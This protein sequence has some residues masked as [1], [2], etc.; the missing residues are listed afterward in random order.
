MKNKYCSLLPYAIIAVFSA[1]LINNMF[2]GFSWTDEGLYLSNVQRYLSGDRFLIDDW[3]PTQFYEPLL[4]P[5]YAFFIKITGSTDGIFLFFRF[6]T[7]IF[8]SLASFF[9]YSLLSKR[10]RALSS[11]FASLIVLSFSRACL[12]GPSYYTIGFE[13]YLIALLCLYAFFSLSCSRAFLFVSGIFFASSIL[14]N[15]F[16][17]FPYIAVSIFTLILPLSRKHIKEIA[18]VWLGS[19]ASGIIYMIFVF[20]GN[21]LSDILSGLHYTY[22]DPSYKHTIILTIKRLYKMPRLLI[23]P[24][25]IT[26]LP[27]IAL[28]G[29]IKIK[30]IQLTVRKK[31][32]MHMLNLVLFFAN[33]FVRKD[34]GAAVMTF[35]HFTIFEVLLFSDLQLKDFLLEYKNELLYFVI[36]GL[37]LAIFFCFASDTGFGVCAVGMALAAVGEI[38]IVERCLKKTSFSGNTVPRRILTFAPFFILVAFSFL[39]RI[40]SPYRDAALA[41]HVLF[42][43]QFNNGISRIEAGPVKGIYTTKENKAYYDDLLSLLRNISNDTA[44]PEKSV[45][46]AG[47]ATWA[48]TAFPNLHCSAPTTWRTFFDDVRLQAYYEEFPKNPFPDY[49]ILLD[50]KNPSNGGRYEGKNDEENV[51]DT[52]IYKKLHEL[53]Y[54]K[55]EYPSGILYSAE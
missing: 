4:Y 25:I 15:P 36:P 30:K 35:F 3:T 26:W 51:R 8:Q 2:Y 40:N 53:G 55:K 38:L 52:W 50:S 44:E 14:C 19:V 54:S 42:L 47:T 11:C 10:Y 49:V 22:N 33:C 5:L 46:I 45:F 39:F 31:F 28:C 41:P 24:Y 34:C 6:A 43:P 17:V 9:A 32:L 1:I 21:S 7:I 16:L 48:Y 37:I 12:N 18:L 13:S 20:A 23:F 27:M 29:L